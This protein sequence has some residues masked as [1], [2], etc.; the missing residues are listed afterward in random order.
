MTTLLKILEAE[1]KKFAI[2]FKA[3]ID[4]AEYMGDKDRYTP[5]EVFGGVKAKTKEEAVKI[6]AQSLSDFQRDHLEIIS[7]EEQN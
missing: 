7:V 5:E 2:R 1:E 4:N 6:F 3:P